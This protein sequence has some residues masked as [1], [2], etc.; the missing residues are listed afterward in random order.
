MNNLHIKQSTVTTTDG[1]TVLYESVTISKGDERS[2]ELL[3]Q[4]FS[5]GV[6]TLN[7]EKGICNWT[8]LRII[9]VT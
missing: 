1:K 8:Y 2:K 7:V 4:G 6:E 9:K 3:S 5:V